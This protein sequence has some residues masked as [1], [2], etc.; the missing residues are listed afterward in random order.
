METTSSKAA[1][2]VDDFWRLSLSLESIDLIRS[3]ELASY[4]VCRERCRCFTRCSASNWFHK[5]EAFVDTSLVYRSIQNRSSVEHNNC[6][7]S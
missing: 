1:G 3:S 2:C 5:K 6:H 7:F 4:S